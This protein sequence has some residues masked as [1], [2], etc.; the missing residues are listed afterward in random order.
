MTTDEHQLFETALAATVNEL[1]LAFHLK[2]KQKKHAQIF[3]FCI[4]VIGPGAIHLRAVRV[5]YAF[6]VA[7]LEFGPFHYSLPDP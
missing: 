7:P 3:P 2:D 5:L 4:V 6:L 1:D